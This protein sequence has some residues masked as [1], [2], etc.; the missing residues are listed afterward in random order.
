MNSVTKMPTT[1]PSWKSAPRRPRQAGGAISAIYTGQ[2]IEEMPIATP[3]Q[4]R[5]ATNKVKFGGTAE[6]TPDTA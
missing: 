2:I 4:I 3:L 6:R 5:A 1:M